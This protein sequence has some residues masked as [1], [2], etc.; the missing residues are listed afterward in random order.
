VCREQGSVSIVVTCLILA[1]LSLTVTL[2][3]L[4][5][6]FVQQR[7]TEAAAD[8]SALA[9]AQSLIYGTQRACAKASSVAQLNG[10]ELVNCTSDATSVVVV[11]SQQVHSERIRAVVSTV[12]ATSKAGY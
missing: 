4:G 8:L 2:A 6:V 3:M 12:T 9:G 10:T 1:L 7:A 5:Q 11:V